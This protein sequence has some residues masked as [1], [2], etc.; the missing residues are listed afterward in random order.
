MKIE[1]AKIGKPLRIKVARAQLQQVETYKY[2]GVNEKEI[3]ARIIG[4]AR[5]AFNLERVLK[6]RQLDITLRL[7]KILSRMCGPC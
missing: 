2:L 7:I 5:N 3:R 6:D 4:I 1:R